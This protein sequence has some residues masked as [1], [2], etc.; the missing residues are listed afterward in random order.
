MP[1]PAVI[2][3]AYTSPTIPAG[4]DG[5]VIDTPA[6]I[7][8]ESVEMDAL[9]WLGVLVSVTVIVGVLVPAAL[10]VPEIAPEELIVRPLGRPDA[11][12]V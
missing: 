4:K 3:A 10:G 6:A 2:V 1:P 8:I 11:D 9:R 5:F 7:V 12:Q